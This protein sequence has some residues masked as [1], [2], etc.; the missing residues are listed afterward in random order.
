MGFVPSLTAGAR[1]LP[2]QQR[3][4]ELR[5][6]PNKFRIKDPAHGASDGVCG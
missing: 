5:V 6:A 4:I 2:L 1:V 3:E